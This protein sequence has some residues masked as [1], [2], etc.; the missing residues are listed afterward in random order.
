MSMI[1]SM[2]SSVMLY[3]QH[4]HAEPSF[5]P[6]FTT[7]ETFSESF[8]AV[9]DLR[10][11]TYILLQ[12]LFSNAGFGDYKG[13][14][15]VL[16]VPKGSEGYNASV[17]VGSNAWKADAKGVTVDTCTLR[18][19]GSTTSFFASA[20]N[21]S[22]DLKINAPMTDLRFPEQD[23]KK[24]DFDGFYHQDVWHTSSPI[25]ATYTTPQGKG[26]STGYVYLDHGR[27]NLILPNVAQKWIRFRGFYGTD[28]I[29]LQVRV[30]PKEE[31]RGWF[32]VHNN[33]TT[34]TNTDMIISETNFT[35]QGKDSA[36]LTRGDV[37]FVY[38][39]IEAYGTAGSIAKAFIGNPVTTTYNATLQGTLNGKEVEI[40][41]ILE[42]SNVE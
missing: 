2:F 23:I 29:I 31:P 4:S 40:R 9:A 17:N 1:F 36:V 27:S 7:D 14:C 34:L 3:M 26:T 13:A 10:D 41:G 5:Q 21:L 11:G 28:P 22:V 30:P 15:R 24:D 35:I 39:P 32:F 6:N 19:E 33:V 12:L 18:T 16:V 8:T 20:D 38:K 25:S 42:E 37:R